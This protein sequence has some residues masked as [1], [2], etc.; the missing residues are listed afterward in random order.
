MSRTIAFTQGTTQKAPSPQIPA[1]PSS[2]GASTGGTQSAARG[3]QQAAQDAQR[4]AQD[5]KLAAD[6][7]RQIAGQAGGPVIAGQPAPPAPPTIFTE[8]GPPPINPE[9]LIRETVPIVGMMVGM[10][11]II[12]LGFPIV[13]ALIRR[14]ERRMELDSVKASDLQPQIRQ[15]QESLDAMAVELE[16]ISE[17]QRFQA[18]LLAER[19][20]AAP[21]GE[22]R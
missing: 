5:A 2:P 10:V 18:K 1:L 12:F 22:R 13:R 20:G 4:A 19:A 9:A 11:A 3:A 6:V 21:V 7:A 14:N 8:T 15:L 16:R 17:S